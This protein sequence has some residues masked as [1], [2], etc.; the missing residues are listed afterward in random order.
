MSEAAPITNAMT[1]NDRE[2]APFVAHARL[3][4]LSSK[5]DMRPLKEWIVRMQ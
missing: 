1:A 4:E 3:S 2:I 5:R